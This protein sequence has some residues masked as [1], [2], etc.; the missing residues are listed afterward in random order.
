LFHYQQLMA[1][2]RAAISEHRL[3]AFVT[4]SYAERAI[5]DEV[6]EAE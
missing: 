2:L 6:I 5:A 4:A 3:D 1:G